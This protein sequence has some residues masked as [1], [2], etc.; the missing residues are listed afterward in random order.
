MEAQS[1]TSKQRVEG[2]HT[3][4][5]P[6]AGLLKSEDAMHCVRLWRVG[7][8]ALGLIHATA[9][10]KDTS[11]VRFDPFCLVSSDLLNSL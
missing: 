5:I 7:F 10:V 6:I 1:E 2:E 8:V 9:A 11:N 4:F 3:G